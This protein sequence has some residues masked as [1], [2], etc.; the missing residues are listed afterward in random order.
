MHDSS[1]LLVRLCRRR[2]AI[3]FVNTLPSNAGYRYSLL[4]LQAYCQSFVHSPSL[5]T[6]LNSYLPQDFESNRYSICDCAAEAIMLAR[7]GS[8]A[9]AAV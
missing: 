8:R 6:I 3:L 1:C 9:A 4:S 7:T 5:Q 2:Y